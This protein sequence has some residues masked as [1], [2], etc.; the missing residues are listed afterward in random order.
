MGK[1]AVTS[2]FGASI[3]CF[4]SCWRA[5]SCFLPRAQVQGTGGEW[6]KAAVR[7]LE[8]PVFVGRRPW[9]GGV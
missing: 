9:M 6:P 8:I 7:A 5:R 2:K 3:V 4:F 1:G